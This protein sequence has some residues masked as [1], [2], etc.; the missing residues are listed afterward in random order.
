MCIHIIES[1]YYTPENIE[2]QLYFNKIC[3]SRKK[4]KERRK[5]SEKISDGSDGLY[6]ISWEGRQVNSGFLFRRP[7]EWWFNHLNSKTLDF[8][9]S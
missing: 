7:S 6:G 4:I 1:L 2:N 9:G 5:G 8:P 3:I